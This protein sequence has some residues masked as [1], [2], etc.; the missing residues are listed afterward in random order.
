VD[1]SERESRTCALLRR[2][3]H[4]PRSRRAAG[5]GWRSLPHHRANLPNRCSSRN[6]RRR[7][8]I[9]SQASS[10][11]ISGELGCQSSCLTCASGLRRGSNRRATTSGS[12]AGD[13]SSKGSR[14]AR[15]RQRAEQKTWPARRRANFRP[16]L[17]HATVRSP[18][19]CGRAFFSRR[20]SRRYSRASP[21]RAFRPKRYSLAQRSA[22]QSRASPRSFQ[23]TRPKRSGLVRAGPAAND[24]G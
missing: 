23:V 16:Q 11:R 13:C 10:S 5:V 19:V 3:G 6:H 7:V 20:A 4:S 22:S 24:S 21:L 14:P 15:W 9:V 12:G 2:Q 1:P 17:T 18:L 8:A